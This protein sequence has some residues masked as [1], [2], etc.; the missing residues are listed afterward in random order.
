[1]GLRFARVNYQ[2]R[3]VIGVRGHDRRGR[4]QLTFGRAPGCPLVR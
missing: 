3:S 1:M 2:N 4:I